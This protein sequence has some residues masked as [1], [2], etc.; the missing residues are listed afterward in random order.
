MAIADLATEA[1]ATA[2]IA[3]CRLRLAQGGE[4]RGQD[5]KDVIDQL[6]SVTVNDVTARTNVPPVSEID[7]RNAAEKTT[8]GS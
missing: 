6:E 4:I 8:A 1:K 3:K 5:L 2:L 7:G